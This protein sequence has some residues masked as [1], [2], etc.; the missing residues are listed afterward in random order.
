MGNFAKR[1]HRYKGKGYK[2]VWQ[3]REEKQTDV[4]IS[5]NVTMDAYE[6]I[7][8]RAL[9]VYLDTD[10]LPIF[11]NLKL[12]FPLKKLITVAPPS[13]AH[14]R[15]LLREAHGHLVIKRSQLEK[16]LFG[17]RIVKGGKLIAIRPS[18]Y[19]PPNNTAPNAVSP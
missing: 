12:R 2:A 4:A 15:D 1:D 7:F 6:D 3:R 14:H 13:R 17:A 5:V 18:S 10:M 11:K 16:S 19:F 9:I 8:D